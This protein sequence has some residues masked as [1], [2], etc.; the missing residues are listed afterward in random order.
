M[1]TIQIL[2]KE[3]LSDRKYPLQYI[4]FEKPDAD[5]KFQNLA[6]EVYFRPDAAVV[7]LV[8]DERKKIMLIKQFRLPTF[9]NGNDHG[10]LIE[11]CAGLIDEGE[12][13]EQTA[14]REVEEET[15]YQIYDLEKIGGAYSSP[16]GSTEY[17]HLF[18]AKYNKIGKT[19]KGGGLEEEG[20]SI[21]VLE[22]D[23]AE[24]REKLKNG[25]FRDVKTILLLQH[26]FL[27]KR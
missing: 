6:K 25:E 9:L 11:A 15:G 18:I 13:P 24:A 2:N 16:G 12:T 3:T 1:S 17:F 4:T 8:D 10:Y 14:H 22:L 5:G 26:F 7:L 23:F 27:T 21:E 20:E 19:S